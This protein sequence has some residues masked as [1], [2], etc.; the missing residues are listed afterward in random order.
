MC[1]FLKK[2]NIKNGDYKRLNIEEKSGYNF[3]KIANV[4]DLDPKLLLIHEIT[5][6]NS[7]STMFE[8][9]YEKE[10][11]TPYIVF[12]DI[13]CIFRKSGINKYLVFCEIEKNKTILK[14]YTKIIDDKRS[15]FVHNRRKFICNW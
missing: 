2:Y 3:I 1:F 7:G 4:N 12:N 5:N 11:N 10:S 6:F 13:E 9:I 15:N 8:I 14:N